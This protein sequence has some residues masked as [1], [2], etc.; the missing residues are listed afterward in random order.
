[1]GGCHAHPLLQGA[2]GHLLPWPLFQQ[3]CMC[4]CDLEWEMGAASLGEL[5]HAL[6]KQLFWTGGRCMAGKG[7]HKAVWGN[8]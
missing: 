8:D 2:Q 7:L 5:V 6:D 3:V 1:M 4:V